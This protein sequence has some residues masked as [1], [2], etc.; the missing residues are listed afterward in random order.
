MRERNRALDSP[1][2]EIAH[3]LTYLCLYRAC[4]SSSQSFNLDSFH[5]LTSA[6]A[7]RLL[8]LGRLDD[9][10]TSESLSALLSNPEFSRRLE[11]L[12]LDRCSF[13]EL[14]LHRLMSECT[15]LLVLALSWRWLHRPGDQHRARAFEN[16]F[17]PV[18]EC[19]WKE[20]EEMMRGD[21]DRC[22]DGPQDRPCKVRRTRSDSEQQRRLIAA[23]N[24]HADQPEGEI[25]IVSPP[26]PPVAPFDPSEG[27]PVDLLSFLTGPAAFRRRLL[28]LHLDYCKKDADV[29]RQVWR[30]YPRLV[31][32]PQPPVM[33]RPHDMSPAGL[34]FLPAEQPPIGQMRAERLSSD[35]TTESNFR[36]LRA[37]KLH[38]RL[39]LTPSEQCEQSRW[40]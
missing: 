12:S 40:L 23:S 1:I 35:R 37:L 16:T 3:L 20:Y 34:D 17:A 25:L 36:W 27:V 26:P 39:P 29:A 24:V 32:W 10:T 6:P 31:C 28:Y 5:A 7:L 22:D 14:G 18:T 2:D 30:R 19:E 8:T 38:C 21:D 11:Y 9:G 13:G 33:L 4:I 15:S